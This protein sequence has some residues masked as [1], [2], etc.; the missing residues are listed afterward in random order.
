ME[1]AV[2]G[3]ALTP[4]PLIRPRVLSWFNFQQ[5]EKLGPKFAMSP[6]VWGRP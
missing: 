3:V 5:Q 1:A 6:I 4:F 2:A